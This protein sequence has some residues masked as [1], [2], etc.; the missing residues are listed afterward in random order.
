[1]FAVILMRHFNASTRLSAVIRMAAKSAADD[2][3]KPGSAVILLH[4]D[5]AFL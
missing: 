1:M 3:I 2:R 5:W 4:E